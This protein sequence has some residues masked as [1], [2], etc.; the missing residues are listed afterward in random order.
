[1]VAEAREA[2]YTTADRILVLSGPD[3]RVTRPDSGTIS[4]S[5]ITVERETGRIRFEG[6]VEGVFI[7]G[8]KG[9]N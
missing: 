3:S 4:G 9:L 6:N 5:R 2:V 8:E 7:P 1:M